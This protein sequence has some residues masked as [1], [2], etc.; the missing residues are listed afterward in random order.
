[1]QAAVQQAIF[2]LINSEWQRLPIDISPFGVWMREYSAIAPD[3]DSVDFYAFPENVW[4]LDQAGLRSENVWK[5]QRLVTVRTHFPETTIK[6]KRPWEIGETAFAPYRDSD[7]SYYVEV[8][9][10]GLWGRAWR[11]DIS[12]EGVI[13]NKKELWRA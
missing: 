4:F 13:Q 3:G 6:R 7:S 5:W 1:M 9:W 2:N 12:A 8:M 11:M 10:D